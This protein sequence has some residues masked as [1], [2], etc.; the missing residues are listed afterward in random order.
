[1]KRVLSWPSLEALQKSGMKQGAAADVHR[2]S[3]PG[4]QSLMTRGQDFQ[5]DSAV[6]S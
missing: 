6:A 1:M 5:D 3:T 4:L 2:R